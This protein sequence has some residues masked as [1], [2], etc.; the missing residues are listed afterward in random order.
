LT[1]KIPFTQLAV[2]RAIKAARLEGLRVTGIAK[3]GT[4]LV[5]D[6]DTERKRVDAPAVAPTG[7]E[8]AET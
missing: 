3:D 8:D 1:T 7:Y 2:R 6:G 5:E 4:V